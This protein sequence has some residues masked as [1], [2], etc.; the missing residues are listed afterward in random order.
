MCRLAAYVGQPLALDQFLR[1]PPHSL[2]E[3]AH[4]PRETLSATLNADGVGV[5]W[6]A[7]DGGPAA[8]RSTLP[9]WG[10]ANLPALGRSLTRP[11]WLAN[12][13]SATDPLSIAVANTMPFAADGLLFL[14]NGF[15]SGFAE[16]VRTRMRAW[17]RPE[18]E[19]GIAGTTD[20]EYVFAALRQL[21]ADDPG[22]DLT[23]HVERLLGLLR[24]WMQGGKALLNLA[25]SDGT[26]VVAVRH[27][28]AAAPPSLYVHTG[29]DGFAGGRL[30]ASEPLDGDAGWTPV[31]SDHLVVLEADAD[32]A[33]R[34]LAG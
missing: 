3:Q 24:D 18:V 29:H 27:A 28:L 33:R 31:P 15:L 23:V 8:Y 6:Y 21:A 17:L 9:A 12:V 32:V 4:A 19:A 1:T 34:P 5:G 30:V 2:I 13:R 10:D 11:L 22:A 16:V 7:D 25:V 26:R 14:H 20:S